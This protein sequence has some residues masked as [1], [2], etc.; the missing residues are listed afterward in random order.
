M[1]PGFS[2]W[3]KWKSFLIK[4]N[5]MKE[6][7][8]NMGIAGFGKSAK[9]FHLPILQTLP[10]YRIEAVL[11]RSGNSAKEIIENV[12][13]VKRFE[14]L[15]KNDRLNVIL[16]S[17][18]NE[19][20]YEQAAAALSAG[21]HVIV[22]KPFTLTSEE[23][24]RLEDLSRNMDRIVTVY[25]NR[26]WD[27]DFLTLQSIFHDPRLGEVVEMEISFNR[28]RNFQRKGSWRESDRPGSGILYDLGPH[29]IDQALL[30]LGKP[31]SLF[32]DV[33][34]LRNGSTADDSFLIYLYYPKIRVIL[35]AG[36]LVPE[37]TPHFIIRGTD[38]SYVKFGM[39]PQE[40]AL[41]SG[42][43]PSNTQDWGT[44]AKSQW[45]TI[46]SYDGKSIQQE[47]IKTKAGDYREFYRKLATS[48]LNDGDLPVEPHH[49]RDVINIIELAF[50]SSDR[51][52]VIQ[53]A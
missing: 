15:L 10:E 48:I 6:K 26:R 4:E 40:E 41:K 44:E 25:H 18:P 34:N 31:D 49:A 35:R 33:R 12:E 19:F 1:E 29:L 27:G 22:E 51:Q 13:V 43:N 3:F 16:I 52:K 8:I 11:E 53:L 21:K 23:A 28:F 38:G 14:D 20:H 50:E 46:Y 24:Q 32:A 36:M 47:K 30:L 37:E 9:N 17:T 42:N 7:S 39:D 45:G 2:V 5:T